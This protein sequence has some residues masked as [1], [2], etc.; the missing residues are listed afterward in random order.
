MIHLSDLLI[1]TTSQQ[2]VHLDGT[3]E[4]LSWS[5]QRICIML[6]VVPVAVSNVMHDSRLRARVDMGVKLF[7]QALP[8]RDAD[9]R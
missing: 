8:R 3:K 4:S 1:L 5:R 9:T 6:R 2:C 7:P